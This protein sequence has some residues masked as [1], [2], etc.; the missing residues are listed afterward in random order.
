MVRSLLIAVMALCLAMSVVAQPDPNQGAGGPGGGR[1]NGGGMP[2]GRQ[3]GGLMNADNTIFEINVLGIFIIHN[4][5]IAKYNAN[6][7]PV[8]IKELF[9]PLPPQPKP[10][11]PQKITDDERAKLREWMGIVGE[12]QAPFSH[13]VKDDMLHLVIGQ[14]YFRVNLKTLAVE[15][16]GALTPPADPNGAAN[17]QRGQFFRPAP[18]LK[19][20]GGT[21][22]VLDGQALFAV[23][24]AK[25][26][27]TAATMPKEMFPAIDWANMGFGNRGNNQGGPGGQNGPG[28]NRQGG[29]QGGGGNQ[30]QR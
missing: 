26:A 21:L 2:G 27:V 1:G 3:G 22:F 10:A 17:P 9:D 16:K 13:L 19:L 11:D 23:D 20:E 18:M 29:G 4:G 15:A 8:G 24:T 7:N 6:L 28:G 5:V 12:R 30:P 14:H 25:G